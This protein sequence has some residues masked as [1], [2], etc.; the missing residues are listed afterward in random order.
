MVQQCHFWLPKTIWWVG[1]YQSN[2]SLYAK[3][4]AY[5]KSWVDFKDLKVAN[6]SPWLQPHF[7]ND[8]DGSFHDLDGDNL[9]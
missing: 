3:Y 8:F 5:R 9:Q 1:E 4:V 7:L 6:P 2:I